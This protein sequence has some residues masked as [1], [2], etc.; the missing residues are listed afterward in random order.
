MKI[1]R[2][3]ANAIRDTSIDA[4]IGRIMPIM[5]RE[6]KMCNKKQDIIKKTAAAE[7]HH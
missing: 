7:A 1:S 6:Y 2:H 5:G 3:S 4:D